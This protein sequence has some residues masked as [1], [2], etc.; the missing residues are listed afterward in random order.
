MIKYNFKNE[1]A[2][3]AIVIASL[4]A[5]LAAYSW[6]GI[7]PSDEAIQAFNQTYLSPLVD[8]ND[9]NESIF[10]MIAQVDPA[11]T[12]NQSRINELRKENR[13][14]V[15]K[16]KIINNVLVNKS[17][18]KKL[19]ISKYAADAVVIGLPLASLLNQ[20]SKVR[21]GKSLVNSV[22]IAITG[23]VAGG[24]DLAMSADE[25]LF[26]SKL[27]DLSEEQLKNNLDLF[28]NRYLLN[29]EEICLLSN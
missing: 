22:L 1:I 18:A 17:S 4:S 23:V 16:I 8:S 20:I 6:S 24:T 12:A 3:F 10:N 27:F 5:P 29:K 26:T 28:A 25:R 2:K 7:T 19:L 21:H 11:L 13:L 15:K 9:D 14:L